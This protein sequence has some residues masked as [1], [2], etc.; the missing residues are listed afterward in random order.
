MGARL[1]RCRVVLLVLLDAVLAAEID[2]AA[3]ELDDLVLADRLAGDRAD[4][5]RRDGR[6]LFLRHLGD[7]GV[8]RL[9]EFLHAAFA[10]DVDV[11]AQ[12]RRFVG[13]FDAILF[14]DRA[15]ADRAELI[16]DVLLLAVGDARRDRGGDER[17][18]KKCDNGFTH[19]FS[20]RSFDLGGSAERQPDANYTCG[21][22]ARQS[23]I[24]LL[25][26][27]STR[28]AGHAARYLN[29]ADAGGRIVAH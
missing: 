12:A 9:A 13:I 26:L 8:R 2:L 28:R 14:G 29:G 7:E 27:A 5:V 10:A 22:A 11:L 17:Q 4:G 15:A 20:L 24:L 25:T 23:N 21:A 18:H 1:L 19:N 6:A 3:F 16:G